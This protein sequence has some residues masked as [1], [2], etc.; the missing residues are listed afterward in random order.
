[1]T[2]TSEN[3]LIELINKGV[4][5]DLIYIDGSH[6]AKDVLSDAILSWKLLKPSGVMIFDDYL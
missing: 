2:G 4:L 1:M 6:L 5:A 3:K